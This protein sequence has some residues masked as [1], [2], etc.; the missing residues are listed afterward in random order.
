[1]PWLDVVSFNIQNMLLLALSA[2]HCDT[3]AARQKRVS[4]CEG[5]LFLA[6]PIELY[7]P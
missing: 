1:M 7:I 6:A 3:Y 2:L 5:Y 4:R